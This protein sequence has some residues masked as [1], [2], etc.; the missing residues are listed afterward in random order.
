MKVT[1]TFNLDENWDDYK[2]VNPELLINDM[3][4]NWQVKDG[5]SIDSYSVEAWV[6]KL[7]LRNLKDCA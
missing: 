4:D 7:Q 1:V 2:N 6:Q 3:F 5:L